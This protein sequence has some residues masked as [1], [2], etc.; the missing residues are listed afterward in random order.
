MVSVFSE[1]LDKSPYKQHLKSTSSVNDKEFI[2]ASIYFI[3]A[4]L[5]ATAISPARFKVHLLD[6][7]VYFDD[8]ISRCS[9]SLQK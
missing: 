3:D 7:L 9:V 6:D 4:V 1:N 8:Q 5:L 2:N